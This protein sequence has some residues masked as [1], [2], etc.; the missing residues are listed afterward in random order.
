MVKIFLRVRQYVYLDISEIQRYLGD[1]REDFALSHILEAKYDLM[2]NPRE[3]P[4]PNNAGFRI[5]RKK[6][7]YGQKMDKICNDFFS[8]LKYIPS[9]CSPPLKMYSR[10]PH[11]LKSAAFKYL[12]ILWNIEE[13]ALRDIWLWRGIC[14]L[15][16][17]PQKQYFEINWGVFAPGGVIHP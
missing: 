6:L 7:T 10:T 17:S 1:F 2:R 3:N 11:M 8:T 14:C 5:L 9:G 16:P 12:R 15:G 4:N 13:M